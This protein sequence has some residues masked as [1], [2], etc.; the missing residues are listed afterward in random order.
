MKNRLSK[1]NIFAAII[2]LYLAPLIVSAQVPRLEV[3]F[4][5]DP[6]FSEASVLPGDSVSGTV[7]VTNNSGE[8][9]TVITEAINVS[10]PDSLSD[11]MN[12]TIEDDSSNTFYD[13]GDG[14]F[15]DFLTGGAHTLTNPLSDG[16]S[17]VFTFTVDF[18]EATGNDF[19]KTELGFDLCVGFLDELS[20]LDCGG[21]SIGDEQGTEGGGQTQ[22]DPPTLELTSGGGGPVDLLHLEISNERVV[23]IDDIGGAAI[24]AW[25]TNLFST[26]Q[27]VYGLNSG[28][29]YSL[30]PS[31]P[32]FG[33]PFATIEDEY[34]VLEHVAI[35]T[36]LIPGEG[37]LYRVVSRASPPTVSY[38][39]DFIVEDMETDEG[40]EILALLDTPPDTFAP[41]GAGSSGGGTNTSVSNTFIA[42]EIEE[43]AESGSSEN[44]TTTPTLAEEEV[45][46]TSEPQVS[47]ESASLEEESLSLADRGLLAAAF[48]TGFFDGEKSS[49]LIYAGLNLLLIYLVHVLWRKFASS[50]STE[51]TV[52]APSF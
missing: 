25:E 17:V 6:L 18:L 45:E 26:S 28:G 19:Q 1:K 9:Q 23:D 11:E 16:D 42:P 50:N 51:K 27:V 31:L 5:P 33:Y 12:L 13:S 36:G 2:V 40:N 4:T 35:L 37:Y 15:F 10:D 41:S 34:K 43:E 49:C 24:I 21:T 22:V 52:N 48:F 7:E 20:G 30:N 14:T 32:N 44:T 38:E 3:V 46:E 29:P 39:H 8:E 47:M